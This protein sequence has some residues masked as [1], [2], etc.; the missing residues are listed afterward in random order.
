M[1]K[2]DKKELTAIEQVMIGARNEI[3]DE[4][5]TKYKARVKEKLRSLAQAEKVVKNIQRELKDL[6][7]SIAEELS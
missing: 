4:I 6:E 5:C 7:I 1:T 3:N 2:T